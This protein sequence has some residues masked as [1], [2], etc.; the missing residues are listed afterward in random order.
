MRKP[1]TI[2]V[3]MPQKKLPKPAPSDTARFAQKRE[4]TQ[5]EE[6]ALLKKEIAL[7]DERIKRLHKDLEISRKETEHQKQISKMFLRQRT[8][9]E[10]ELSR[11]QMKLI[12]KDQYIHGARKDSLTSSN[13]YATFT[14][15][16]STPGV[17]DKEVT[18]SIAPKPRWR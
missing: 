9:Y 12:N 18:I 11:V 6:I 3:G 14:R 16:A 15:K 8:A 4:L 5:A 17:P 1:G 7:K 10:E 13:Q 2:L